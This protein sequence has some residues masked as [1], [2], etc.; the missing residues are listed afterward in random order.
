M[1]ISPLWVAITIRIDKGMTFAFQG[2][3]VTEIPGL[4]TGIQSL[5]TLQ[6]YKEQEQGMVCVCSFF[7]LFLSKNEQ[8][9]GESSLC[10]STLSESTG[11]RISQGGNHILLEEQPSVQT[12]RNPGGLVNGNGLL[13]WKSVLS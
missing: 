9:A 12:W 8:C 11:L 2:N 13:N 5:E 4:V 6:L 10:S 7:P 3:I 1:G